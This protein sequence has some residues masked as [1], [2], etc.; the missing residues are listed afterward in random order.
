MR[1]RWVLGDTPGGGEGNG[2]GGSGD[3]PRFETTTS[4]SGPAT[5]T[6]GGCQASAPLGDVAADGGDVDDIAAGDADADASGADAILRD[7]D[8]EL[9]L[10]PPNRPGRAGDDA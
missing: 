1:R 4:L 2:D 8:N 5:L 7:G 9:D 3:A 6:G 10:V